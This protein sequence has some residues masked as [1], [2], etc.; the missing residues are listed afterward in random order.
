[1]EHALRTALTSVLDVLSVLLVAA[2]LGCVSTGLILVTLAFGA[3]S[4]VAAIGV[5][6]TVAGVVVFVASWLASR[7]PP[8]PAPTKSEAR[9]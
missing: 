1:M 2:G 7:P 4:V 8:P 6:A 3:G 5:G 9:L